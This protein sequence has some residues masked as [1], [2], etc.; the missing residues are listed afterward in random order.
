M[1][2][3]Y[4]SASR[5][6]T[7]AMSSK[8]SSKLSSYAL[9]SDVFD[10]HYIDKY[11]LEDHENAIASDSDTDYDDID[12]DLANDNACHY[13]SDSDADS[14]LEDYKVHF[15]MFKVNS[16]AQFTRPPRT[17][18]SSVSDNFDDTPNRDGEFAM[19]PTFHHPKF[20]APAMKPSSKKVAALD[21][22]VECIVSTYNARCKNPLGFLDAH[23]EYVGLKAEVPRVVASGTTDWYDDPPSFARCSDAY[24][25]SQ[26]K[27]FL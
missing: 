18:F 16:R 17:S 26:E 5:R 14:E 3:Y 1:E 25:T 19:E 2:P 21:D 20:A 11:R 13:V 22:L 15:L 9:L 12:D 8:L 27:F 24:E 4:E 6:D 7:S 10:Y 23:E